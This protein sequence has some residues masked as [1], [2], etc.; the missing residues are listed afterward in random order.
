[1]ILTFR[2]LVG[3]KTRPQGGKKKI[4]KSHFLISIAK[5]HISITGITIIKSPSSRDGSASEKKEE[6]K[7]KVTLCF[8]SLNNGD[9]VYGEEVGGNGKC[10]SR[11]SFSLSR[12]AGLEIGFG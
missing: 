5:R 10:A 1:M 6:K 12:T 9:N 3:L 11:S 2:P 4:W 8:L 7:K